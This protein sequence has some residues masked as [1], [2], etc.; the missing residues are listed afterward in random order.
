MPVTIGIAAVGAV[1]SVVNTVSN[2]SDMKKRRLYEQNLASLSYDQKEALG[3]LL[4]KQT[5]EEAKMQILSDTL[6]KLNTARINSLT[7]IETE[8]QKTKKYLYV[9]LAVGAIVLIGGGILLLKRNKK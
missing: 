5:S 7:Q 4:Q 1:T 9:V 8:K 3:K 2:V 6:G